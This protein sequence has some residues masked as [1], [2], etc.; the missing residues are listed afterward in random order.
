MRSDDLIA[1]TMAA[2]FMKVVLPAS[3]ISP[4]NAV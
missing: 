1:I 4:I 3:I 2:L